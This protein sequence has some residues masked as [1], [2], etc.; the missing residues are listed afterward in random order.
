MHE[1]YLRYNNNLYRYVFISSS[2]DVDGKVIH[3]A[4]RPPPSLSISS[5]SNS[6]SGSPGSDAAGGNGRGT[7]SGNQASGS[8]IDE[9]RGRNRMTNAGGMRSSPLFRALDGMVVGTMT[10][11]FNVNMNVHIN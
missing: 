10:I 1:K 7:S 2:V 4:E 8:G 5:S 11:P 3:V 9:Y 6:Q